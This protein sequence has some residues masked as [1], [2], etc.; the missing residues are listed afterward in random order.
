LN[1]YDVWLLNGK[2]MKVDLSLKF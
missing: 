2:N 1:V